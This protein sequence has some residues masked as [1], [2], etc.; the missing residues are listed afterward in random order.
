MGRY[1]SYKLVKILQNSGQE[2][3]LQSCIIKYYFRI[4]FEVAISQIINKGIE[5]HCYVYFC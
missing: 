4:I 1:Y 2:Y 3:G 5:F